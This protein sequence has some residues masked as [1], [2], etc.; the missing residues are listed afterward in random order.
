MPFIRSQALLTAQW[1]K[2]ESSTDSRKR[3]DNNNN[4]RY[5]EDTAAAKEME[6]D[7]ESTSCDT[8]VTLSHT[9]LSL[10]CRRHAMISNPKTTHNSRFSLTSLLKEGNTRGWFAHVSWEYFGQTSERSRR[11]V[12]YYTHIL[13]PKGGF[14]LF[15]SLLCRIERRKKRARELRAM[16]AEG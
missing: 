6:K 5:S 9:L 15:F 11:K 1:D 2:G 3:E 12:S 10:F 7:D 4:L 14:T 8:W 13:L 16:W